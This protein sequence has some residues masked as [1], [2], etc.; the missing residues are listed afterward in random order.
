LRQGV[1]STAVALT[2]LLSGEALAD[3]PE[4]KAAGGSRVVATPSP[5]DPLA[6][7][8]V[9]FSLV[10]GFSPSANEWRI[11]CSL[12]RDRLTRD[13]CYMGLDYLVNF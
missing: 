1:I 5:R 12:D 4:M 7:D 3:D 10:A 8:R 11:D 2:A 6:P 9:S 13:P